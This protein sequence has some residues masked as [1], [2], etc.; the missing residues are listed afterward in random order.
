MEMLG[1]HGSAYLLPIGRYPLLQVRR[2]HDDTAECL[3]AI[4][5]NGTDT[6]DDVVKHPAVSA[7]QRVDGWDVGEGGRDPREHSAHRCHDDVLGGCEL[8]GQRLFGD[9]CGCGDVG[10]CCRLVTLT[11]PDSKADL[12]Q[13][14]AIFA[15]V[16]HRRNATECPRPLFCLTHAAMRVGSRLRSWRFERQSNGRAA[17]SRLAT[18]SPASTRLSAS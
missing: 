14:V 2:F 5:G 13:F 1:K 3:H 17:V 18:V 4:E 11:H 12:D 8:C 7:S 16:S 10:E 9:I 15:R 6:L